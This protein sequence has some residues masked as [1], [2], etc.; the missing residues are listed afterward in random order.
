LA[1][2]EVPDLKIIKIPEE[3]SVGAD[4]GLIINKNASEDAWRFGMY[5][6]SPDGQKILKNYGFEATAIQH[7]K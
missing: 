4:Y 7:E 2:N 1:Q 6:L 5:I 3:I